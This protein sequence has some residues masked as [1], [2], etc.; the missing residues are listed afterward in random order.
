LKI[1]T[2]DTNTHASSPGS[3][4]VSNVKL[5]LLRPDL[6]GLNNWVKRKIKT[7]RNGFDEMREIQEHLLYGDSQPAVVISIEPLLIA[8]YSEDI[9]CVVLLHFPE[10]YVEIYNLEEGSKL[11][12]INTYLR[13]EYFQ[14]DITPGP[15]CH[16]TWRGFIPY[17]ADF[18]TD[19]FEILENKK[20]E[21]DEDHWEYVYVLGI[22]YLKEFP[23]VWR[24]GRQILFKE[25]L[26]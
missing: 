14:S 5:K 18:L 8:A 12:S 7:M 1:K 21:I 17:I 26:W 10:K 22:E 3:I 24:D 20:D 11:I 6:F 16:Y 2:L 4:S 13:G 23:N 9:D 25:F 19:D 15:N